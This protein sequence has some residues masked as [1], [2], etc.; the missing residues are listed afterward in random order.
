[1]PSVGGA[2]E[3]QSQGHRAAAAVGKSLWVSRVGKSGSQRQIRRPPDERQHASSRRKTA[4]KDAEGVLDELLQLP[5]HWW[6][7]L[8]SR[9]G[10]GLVMEEERRRP[11]VEEFLCAPA[12]PAPRR[13]LSPSPVSYTLLAASRTLI[14]TFGTSS[15]LSPS[16]KLPPP[17]FL[18]PFGL[19]EAYREAPQSSRAPRRRTRPAPLLP[20]HYTTTREGLFRGA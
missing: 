9:D 16:S 5:R 8:R 10:G 3:G 6:T 4:A 17:S 20:C 19:L 18:D 13:Q 12:K 14:S 7:M 11:G 2:V 1:M 15:S